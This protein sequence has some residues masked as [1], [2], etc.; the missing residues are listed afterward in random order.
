MKIVDIQGQILNS[1][2]NIELQCTV[3]D[4]FTYF[5]SKSNSVAIQNFKLNFDIGVTKFVCI[6]HEK[7]HCSHFFLGNG[8]SVFVLFKES[9]KSIEINVDNVL[10]YETGNFCGSFIQTKI[11]IADIALELKKNVMI[12]TFID[13]SERY[14]FD[15]HHFCFRSKNGVI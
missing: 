9:E 5:Y 14:E 2:N 1:S 12:I 4:V 8:S 15:S 6:S 3:H 10:R 13:K 11:T 7:I